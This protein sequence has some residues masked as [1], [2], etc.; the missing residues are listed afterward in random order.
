MD[1]KT[2]GA[3]AA[4]AGMSERTGRKWEQGLLPSQARP[5]RTW[6]TRRDP[7]A[8][9]WASEIEPLL[10]RDDEGVLE[11][12]FLFERL[13]ER[14][15]G[16]F[17][18][19]QVRTLQRHVREWRAL[20]GPPREVYFAQVHPPGREAQID[21]THAS[22]LG[23]TIAGEP[24]EHL[25]FELVLSCSGWRFAQVAFGETFE[26]L[27]GGLQG[28]LWAL[29]GV[30]EVVR[31]DNLSAATHELRQSGGRALTQRFQ[32]VL[33]HYGLRS[34]RISPGASHENGVVEEL[35][36]TVDDA[37]L[38]LAI[39]RLLSKHPP[40]A[41]AIYLHAFNSMNAESWANLETIL[42]TEPRLAL[43]RGV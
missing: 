16:Q 12:S 28:A 35:P 9:V 30:T 1:G 43:S 31:S 14:Y 20:Q 7:F 13:L 38:K 36:K 10:R 34:T 37:T 11:S 8:G 18:P 40:E 2:Q 26:A 17:G 29:G 3:A 23:V 42:K 21:F 24:L 6:R 15:P 25:L 32:A 5:P 41:V 39:E 4:A 19:G 33:D 22:E 27:V